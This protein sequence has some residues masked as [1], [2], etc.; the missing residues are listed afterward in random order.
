MSDPG[1][2]QEPLLATESPRD[3][4]NTGISSA[5]VL[6]LK[7]NDEDEEAKK[8]PIWGLA[9]ELIVL[10]LGVF[11]VDLYFDVNALSEFL[12]MKDPSGHP[13]P[14]KWWFG[15]NLSAIVMS[16]LLTFTELMS[17]TDQFGLSQVESL[18]LGMSFPFQLH[19]AVLVFLSIK[20][21]KVHPL[22]V[23]SKFAEAG[24]EAVSSSLIQLYSIIFCNSEFDFATC[25]FSG[26]DR[27]TMMLSVL[28]SVVS[29]SVA[30]SMFDLKEYGAS[31]FPGSIP[32]KFCFR[33]LLVLTFRC[34]ETTSRLLTCSIFQFVTRP[35]GGFILFGCDFLGILI[36]TLINGGSKAHIVPNMFCF[37]NPML[38]EYNVLSIQHHQYYAFRIAELVVM[39][40]A[41]RM[42]HAENIELLKTIPLLAVLAKIAI[43]STILWVLMYPLLRNKFVVTTMKEKEY[44]W[45]GQDVP[46]AIQMKVRN[47]MLTKEDHL[48]SDW[49]RVL[50]SH[51]KKLLKAIKDDSNPDKKKSS[52]GD[53]SASLPEPNNADED[54]KEQGAEK[55]EDVSFFTSLE[56]SLSSKQVD[57]VELNRTPTAYQEHQERVAYAE[58]AAEQHQERV[59]YAD[60]VDGLVNDLLMVAYSTPLYYDS[61]LDGKVLSE[62]DRGSQ[63]HIIGV[64]AAED[65]CIK[66]LENASQA[67][68]KETYVL[69]KKYLPCHGN[70]E[71]VLWSSL[72]VSMKMAPL[73]A[74]VIAS[75]PVGPR[76]LALYVA[77]VLRRYTDACNTKQIVEFDNQII[78]PDEVQ[79][80]V[81]VKCDEGHVYCIA[82]KRHVRGATCI[83][84]QK[85]TPKMY[86]CNEC[87]VIIC[88]EHH[89]SRYQ[90]LLA[91]EGSSEDSSKPEEQEL[92][93]LIMILNTLFQNVGQMGAVKFSGDAKT[94]IGPVLNVVMEHLIR[95]GENKSQ[96]EKI[97]EVALRRNPITRAGLELMVPLV[98]GKNTPGLTLMTN[99]TAVD[100]FDNILK[101]EAS[102]L[103]HALPWFPAAMEAPTDKVRLRAL[104]VLTKY[105]T[106]AMETA[107]DQT[108]DQ[109]VLSKIVEYVTAIGPDLISAQKKLQARMKEIAEQNT[110]VQTKAIRVAAEKLTS[111]LSQERTTD[112][113]IEVRRLVGKLQGVCT[114]NHISGKVTSSGKSCLSLKCSD[115]EKRN[116]AFEGSKL[117]GEIVKGSKEEVLK[118]LK[119]SSSVL[120]VSA[121]DRSS[122]DTLAAIIVGNVISWLGAEPFV[123]C[124][125]CEPEWQ[126]HLFNIV[127]SS[128]RIGISSDYVGCE[129]VL[130]QVCKLTSSLWAKWGDRCPPKAKV[131]KCLED[132]VLVSQE[133]AGG[134]GCDECGLSGRGKDRYRCQEGCNYDLCGDCFAKARGN[135]AKTENKSCP[136]EEKV[137]EKVI[138][139]DAL[140]KT[141]MEKVTAGL[142]AKTDDDDR[143]SVMNTFL[144]SS[145]S[146]PLEG[147][148]KDDLATANDSIRAAITH[149]PPDQKDLFTMWA[150]T[151]S[152]DLD[153]QENPR[154]GGLGKA[155]INFIAKEEDHQTYRPKDTAPTLI[156]RALPALCALD[157]NSVA[158]VGGALQKA[159][160]TVKDSN[161]YKLQ[162]LK[163]IF[164]IGSAFADADEL[165]FSLFHPWFSKSKEKGDKITLADVLA[166]KKPILCFLYTS[167]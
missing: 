68:A 124:I 144:M 26:P 14:Q 76:L 93:Q 38:E 25:D 111:I 28:S 51:V 84:C 88:E 21:G 29:I 159:L 135:D 16:W 57:G 134:W 113:E 157:K 15:I 166:L 126:D 164:P 66:S 30:F 142:Q 97:D 2:S 12:L 60:R 17:I 133:L 102:A 42:F 10:T 99:R 59:A 106:K 63:M 22:L 20:Y 83:D 101:Y 154:V 56:D 54:N 108:D 148:N 71:S 160:A 40:C 32:T 167:W 82:D 114:T 105:C 107:Q 117:D 116:G 143:P 146:K 156:E 19:I 13:H 55:V 79:G 94:G 6:N 128:I 120:N 136:S 1:L 163:K 118:L 8:K 31:G 78:Q 61:N 112:P 96:G 52:A 41:M 104:K 155:I 81:E 150:F 48:C 153:V 37:V 98:F 75:H 33:Y 119:L 5:D 127:E 70:L 24:I 64:A 131:P 69:Y 103:S 67:W 80:Q 58:E 72:F 3:V 4:V 7:D 92:R 137:I 132:H 149:D 115:R 109:I 121:K 95:N 161:K 91:E 158:A 34:A 74:N 145:S 73:T 18:I 138:D 87:E 86:L 152:A 85:R 43:G 151:P 110:S 62:S 23:V 45:G 123:T 129:A 140:W 65:S 77:G 9:L 27:Q 122:L 130:S 35:C 141:L 125:S 50:N 89:Q 162:M 11:Y 90:Q 39:C 49:L 44:E 53:P 165:S 147:A 139:R 47:L 46:S 36:L 100:L